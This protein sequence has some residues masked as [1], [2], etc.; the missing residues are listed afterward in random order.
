MKI[1]YVAWKPGEPNSI[2]VELH[3]T[4]AITDYFSTGLLISYFDKEGRKLGTERQSYPNMIKA[5]EKVDVEVLVHPNIY[6]LEATREI[7]VGIEWTRPVPE[8]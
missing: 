1:S 6:P 5:G 8:Q 3:N 7:K 4:A 2:P